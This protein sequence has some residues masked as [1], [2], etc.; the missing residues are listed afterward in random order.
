MPL[1]APKSYDLLLDLLADWLIEDLV[2]EAD[3]IN[4]EGPNPITGSDPS[5]HTNR[6]ISLIE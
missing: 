6:W 4:G 1:A 3:T 5:I 2:A